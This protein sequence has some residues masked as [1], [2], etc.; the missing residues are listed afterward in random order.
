MM[1]R[2]ALPLIAC[3]AL[4]ATSVPAE[5]HTERYATKWVSL[6]AE[7]TPPTGAGWSLEGL[8]KIRAGYI[9]EEL[10]FWDLIG[11]YNGGLR[12]RLDGGISSFNGWIGF[13]VHRPPGE[14]G[15]LKAIRLKALRERYGP[16]NRH[17]RHICR[18]SEWLVYQAD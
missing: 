7:I 8:A 16:R 17:H 5:A 4:L 6:D 3:A 10:R 9:C 18:P 15:R 11:I 2:I 12:E 13:G 1:L 14:F